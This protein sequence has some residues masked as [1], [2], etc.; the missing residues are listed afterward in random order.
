MIEI[1][2]TDSNNED[3][4]AL[5]KLLDELLAD[6]DGDEHSFYDQ[7]NKIDAL[8]YVIVAY[9]HGKAVGCGAIKEFVPGTMEVKRMYTLPEA[10]GKGIA[11]EVLA[12]LEKWAASLGY[13][14][15]VL[16][17]GIRQQ[18]AVALYKKRGYTLIENYGQYAGVE[19]SV[20]F[21]KIL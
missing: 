18:D 1:I 12:E 5:V 10:R 4:K 11:S 15:T 3:F 21:E 8:K 14:K 20:C 6:L 9:R 19:N 17:T 7:Y 16:E 13:E 2:H